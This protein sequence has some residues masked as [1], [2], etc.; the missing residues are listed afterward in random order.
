MSQFLGEEKDDVSL[1][2]MWVSERLVW[3]YEMTVMNQGDRLTVMFCRKSPTI[4]M[5]MVFCGAE[6]VSRAN[7]IL[8]KE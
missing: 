7:N 6:M 5:K 1:L 2:E 4:E 3:E 8:V